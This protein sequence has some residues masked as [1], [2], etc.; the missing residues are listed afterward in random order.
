M[1][2]GGQHAGKMVVA[3]GQ[4]DCGRFLVTGQHSGPPAVNDPGATKG[5]Q[6]GTREFPTEREKRAPRNGVIM[7]WQRGA[8]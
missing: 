8:P 2:D 5:A 3:A 7:G 6:H 1:H 4:G